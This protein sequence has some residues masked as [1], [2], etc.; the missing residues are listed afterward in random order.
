MIEVKINF[1]D[2][3]SKSRLY[4]ILTK[5]QGDHNILI[6]K[7][8]LKRSNPENRYYW[9]VVIKILCS[10]FGYFQ[11]EMHELLKRLF[12]GYEKANRITGEIE[13]FCKSTKELSTQEA[14]DF[15]EKIRVWALTEYSIYIPLPNE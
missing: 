4:S 3:D 1:N 12:L 15:Y 10:E 7:H 6:K 14:E 8:R 11:E 2:Q 5:L 13:R 9:G